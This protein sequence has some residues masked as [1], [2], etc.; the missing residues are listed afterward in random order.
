MV[1]KTG[2]DIS[3]IRSG[4]LKH[5][6]KQSDNFLPIIDFPL[7]ITQSQEFV[8]KESGYATMIKRDPRVNH[9]SKPNRE[10]LSKMIYDV[11]V[12]RSIDFYDGSKFLSKFVGDIGHPEAWI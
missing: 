5:I 7:D 9:L 8:N 10:I 4:E 11:I 1:V 2:F 3:K 12:N 6:I